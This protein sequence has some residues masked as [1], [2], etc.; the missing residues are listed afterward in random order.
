MYTRHYKA[1]FRRYNDE[2]RAMDVFQDT[3]VKA[4]PK[5][6]VIG[7]EDFPRYLMTSLVNNMNRP[8]KKKMIRVFYTEDTPGFDREDP[9]DIGGALVLSDYGHSQVETLELMERLLGS[10]TKVEKERW[11]EYAECGNMSD[12][13]L[14]GDSKY[15]KSFK[16]SIVTARIKLRKA[17]KRHT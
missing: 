7:K 16:T 4:Y 3:F 12:L 9:E 13:E 10:L 8:P 2:Q 15:A 14:D 5:I 6:D 17:Y 1:A 11:L